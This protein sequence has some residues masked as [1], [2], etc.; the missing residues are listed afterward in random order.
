MGSSGSKHLKVLQT[1]LAN[2][3]DDF[4]GDYGVQMKPAKLQTFCEVEWPTF[5]VAWPTEATL[6]PAIIAHVRDI[7]IGDPGHPDKFPYIV[8]WYILVTCPPDWL[9]FH[10][11]QHSHSG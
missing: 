3:R 11:P 1:M 5:S 6:D 4:L 9:C 10:V 7:V 8:S 2:F